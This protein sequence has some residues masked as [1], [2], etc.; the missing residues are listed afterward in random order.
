MSALPP[1]VEALSALRVLHDSASAAAPFAPTAAP[2]REPHFL[3]TLLAPPP[4]CAPAASAARAAGGG[5]AANASNFDDDDYDSDSDSDGGGAWQSAGETWACGA[6]T[7]A[8]NFESDALCVVCGSAAPRRADAHP[9]ALVWR[10][11]ACTL[12]NSAVAPLCAACGEPAPQPAPQP[13]DSGG[14]AAWPSA[15]R[16]VA[17]AAWSCTGCTLVNGGER[18]TCE[19]CGLPNFAAEEGGDDD[20]DASA[21]FPLR[22]TAG[23]GGRA[24]LACTPRRACPAHRSA[25]LRGA[26]GAAAEA[27]ERERTEAWLSWE[28]RGLVP[29]SRL[30]DGEEEAALRSVDAR[31]RRATLRAAGAPAGRDAAPPSAEQFREMYGGGHSSGDDDGTGGICLDTKWEEGRE[32]RRRVQLLQAAGWRRVSGGRGSHPKWRR[33]LAFGPQVL[34]FASTPSSQRSWNHEAA[35][36]ARADREAVSRLQA[37]GLL[38]PARTT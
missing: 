10:C 7:Y 35:A 36:L 2:A 33:E 4:A 38:Q 37:M 9:V 6:C 1:L 13:R 24:C 20:G 28:R 12:D 31:T 23:P 30:D 27:R 15:P 21:P 11:D 18:A 34:V 16:R 3:E 5:A 17:R 8:S 14:N 25:R 19:A 32:P 26:G 29:L 22:S